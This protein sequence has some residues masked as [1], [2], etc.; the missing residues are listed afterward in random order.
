MVPLLFRA[1]STSWRNSL[2][3]A[4]MARSFLMD[5]I[6]GHPHHP[7]NIVFGVPARGG[8]DEEMNT[9]FAG[10][11]SVSFVS[12]ERWPFFASSASPERW[13]FLWGNSSLSMTP[14]RSSVRAQ[15]CDVERERWTVVSERRSDPD[16]Q[17]YFLFH[18]NHVALIQNIFLASDLVG[19]T[20]LLSLSRM[21]LQNFG[22]MGLLRAFSLK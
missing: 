16:P 21:A 6:L 22:T 18:P 11:G 14:W 10:P 15:S 2:A 17:S 8:V 19:E 13:P 5:F 9:S 12:L 3:M 1:V 20:Q 7:Y 4:C